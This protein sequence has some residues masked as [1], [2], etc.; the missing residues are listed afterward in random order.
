MTRL[1]S[2][3]SSAVITWVLQERA[4][5]AVDRV[6]ASGEFDSVLAGPALTEIIYRSRARGNVSTPS[7]IAAV[8]AAQGLRVEPA[9]EGDLVRGAELLEVSAGNPSEASSRSGSPSTLSLGDA[10]ILAVSERLGADVL[11]GDKYWG[12]MVDAGQLDL[13]V[14]VIP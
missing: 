5:K 8:L 7:Q 2:L 10:L 12:W 4:W 1:L 6:L 11:T 3:D 9:G 14:F 13:R